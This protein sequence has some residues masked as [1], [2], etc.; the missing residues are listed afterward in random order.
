MSFY[1]HDTCTVLYS[2]QI[3]AQYRER[4]LQGTVFRELYSLSYL[5]HLS[6]PSTPFLFLQSNTSGIQRCP[7]FSAGV[8]SKYSSIRVIVSSRY[9]G[10][11]A[12][13]AT[14]KESAF[15]EL[16][17]NRCPRRQSIL[18]ILLSAFFS[19]Y[20]QPPHFLGMSPPPQRICPYS[21]S[22]RA[23]HA[24]IVIRCDGS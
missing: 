16:W 2:V 10:Y 5:R 21:L 14:L 18:Q 17:E 1:I 13:L 11:S 22:I 8:Y 23:A 12:I 24:C 3:H 7:V 19:A 15:R 9:P 6:T 4:M 20:F